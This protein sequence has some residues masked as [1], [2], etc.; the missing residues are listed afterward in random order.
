ME[1]PLSQS[2]I[3][4]Q[5]IEKEK[6][7][8]TFET[9]E[10]ALTWRKTHRKQLVSGTRPQRQ[11]ARQLN[12]CRKRTRCGTEACR[13]CLRE[14]R[15]EWAGELT[16]IFLDR[17]AWTRCSVIMEG[18]LVPYGCLHTF[19]LRAVVKRIQKRIE[20]SGISDRIV[21]GGLDVSLNLND[22][23][24]LGWQFHLYLL[25]EGESDKELRKAVKAAFT[26]EPSAA[27]PYEFRQV[28]NPLE[29]ITYAYKS[30]FHR[31]SSYADEDGHQQ[32]RNLPLK[33]SDQREL[34]QFLAQHKVG[35]R[36]ILRGV[37]RNG[38][39]FALTN[40]G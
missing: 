13:V 16:K 27:K 23:N 10:D 33:N 36:A 5:P 26:P 1:V 24:L 3:N 32:T 12:S 8:M 6:Y 39:S 17:P 31:R 21:I 11:V 35:S 7:P 25:I 19:D 18:L 40:P 34:L 38:K 9:F 20:R 4:A 22:N 28:E 29:A 2:E 30:L 14:F 15:K 37:R